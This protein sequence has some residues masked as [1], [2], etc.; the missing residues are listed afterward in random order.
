[1]T[2]VDWLSARRRDV[3][4]SPA[5]A[6]VD[7]GRGARRYHQGEL[8]SSRAEREPRNGLGLT[9]SRQDFAEVVLPIQFAG[10]L[11]PLMKADHLEVND[12]DDE[13]PS[14]A[15]ARER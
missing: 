10:E 5:C 6:S 13:Q 1:M 3:K 12:G 7:H 15:D 4:R 11:K 14:R 2:G 8:S 9:F